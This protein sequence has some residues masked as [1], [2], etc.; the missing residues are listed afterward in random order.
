VILSQDFFFEGGIV[1]FTALAIL[2]D[3]IG[4]K[5]KIKQ[6]NQHPLWACYILPAVLGMI[7][8]LDSDGGDPVEMLQ[9]SALYCLLSVIDLTFQHRGNLT[10]DFLLHAIY[11]GHISLMCAPPDWT[12]T[13]HKKN[14]AWVSE[15]SANSPE[16]IEEILDSGHN[17]FKTKYANIQDS[18]W[19]SN[20]RSRISH[21]M[22]SMQLQFPIMTNYRRYIV[23]QAPNEIPPSYAPG[24]SLC[25]K[26]RL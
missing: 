23:I 22:I 16:T 12:G 14:L 7:V 18:E 13:A 3:P 26:L 1:T 2:H 25:L 9:R 17:A 8:E 10:C 4:V 21:D 11:K 20:V 5:E 6:I 24:V 19:H 15:H